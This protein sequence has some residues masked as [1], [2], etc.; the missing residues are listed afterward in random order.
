[1]RVLNFA[2]SAEQANMM[3]MSNRPRP[4]NPLRRAMGTQDFLARSVAGVEKAGVKQR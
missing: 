2:P 4:K 3:K 1:M